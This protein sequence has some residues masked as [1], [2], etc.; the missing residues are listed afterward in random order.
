MSVVTVISFILARAP[1][2]SWSLT[3]LW[4]D[5]R[6]TYAVAA[7]RPLMVQV[8]VRVWQTFTHSASSITPTLSGSE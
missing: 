2:L 3:P 7:R 5:T 8:Q 6:M 1:P 4:A